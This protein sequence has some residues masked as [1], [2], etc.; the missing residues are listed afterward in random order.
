MRV[1]IGLK[2]IKKMYKKVFQTPSCCKISKMLPSP[3]LF[4]T[5]IEI[6][7]L[8]A[9]AFDRQFEIRATQAHDD[10]L[11]TSVLV[12]GV[13]VIAMSALAIGVLPQIY[14]AGKRGNQKRRKT[15]EIGRQELEGV[16]EMAR[17]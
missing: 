14:E 3:E 1:K 6:G 12:I 5:W 16:R 4:L 2:K 9:F 10:R 11:V 15:R 17:K 8:V 13:L 7:I